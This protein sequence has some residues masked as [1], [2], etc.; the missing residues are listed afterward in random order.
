MR[1]VVVGAGAVGGVVGGY[2]AR[3]GADVALVARGDHL[4]AIQARGLRV[5][6]P[7]G[8]FLASSAV[9]V[10]S[11]AELDPPLGAAGDVV[12]LA[13]K[14][15]DTRDALDQLVA[16][17]ADGATLPVACLQN[18]VDNEPMVAER[19]AH[20]YGVTVMAPTLFLHPGAVV[21]K[22]GP[23]PA[24]LDIGCYPS[25]VDDTA[26][27]IAAAFEQAGIVSMP[28]PDVLRWKWA[29]L[30]LNL[31]NAVQVVC[32]PAAGASPLAVAAVDEGRAVL[33]AAGVDVA[34]AEE[35]RERRGDT[36]R[37]RID[38]ETGG[39][40]WQSVARGG[41]IETDHL[42]GTIV[43]MGREHGVA[44]PVNSMLLELAHEV[45]E[46]GRG[47]GRMDPDELL[48]RALA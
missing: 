46:A 16:A 18:G 22:A 42:T 31:A 34:S 27:A 14:T 17:G 21:A 15:Q 41:S 37:W 36:L 40:T 25:G 26:R 32:G 47:P 9:A 2:L 48:A 38:P 23:V 43:R 45:A 29:K 13:V 24:I 20:T 33:T 6:T 8:G 19:F 44:T 1:F 28:R 5:D 12:L 3:S 35:D 39:S 11:P 10:G 4:A 30:L 7:D